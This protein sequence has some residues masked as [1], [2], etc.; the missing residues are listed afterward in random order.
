MGGICMNQINEKQGKVVKKMENVKNVGKS[1]SFITY[2]NAG[3]ITMKRE[4]RKQ[5]AK[6]LAN[7]FIENPNFESKVFMAQ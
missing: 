1:I 3:D 5:L 7:N 6:I 4:M 2:D